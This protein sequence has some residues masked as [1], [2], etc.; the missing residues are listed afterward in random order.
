MRRFAR[1]LVVAS[2]AG[3][4]SSL[5]VAPAA[6]S[7]AGAASAGG[8]AAGATHDR[9]VSDL[10]ATNTPE[11][12]DGLPWAIHKIGD[13]VL[14]G[15]DFQ[16]VRDPGGGAIHERPFLFAF[17]AA[18]GEVDPDF[19]PSLA[20]EV[21]AL[22]PGPDSDT[23]YVGGR[24]NH[25]GGQQGWNK[26]V[27]MSLTDG[28]VLTS[29]RAPPMNGAVFDVDDAGGRLYVGGKFTHT[30]A[31]ATHGLVTL[32]PH[33]G[34]RDPFLDVHLTEHHNYDGQ[35]GAQAPVG[36]DRIDITP[37][38][39]TAVVI[40]NF[41]RAN[42][43]DRDQVLLLDLTGASAE[44]RDWHTNHFKPRCS[45][46]AFDKWVRDVSFSPDGSYFVVVTTG[47]PHRNTLCDTASRWETGATGSD[48]HPTW[49]N[50]T[51]GDTLLSVAVTDAAVYVGGHQR[52]QNNHL[53]LDHADTGAVGRPGLAA[54]DPASGVD[55]SWNPGRNPRGHGATVLHASEDGLYVGSDTD[56]VGNWE[57]FRPRL[58]HFPLA[59]GEV[60]PAGQSATLPG[61]VHFADV[62]VD[63]GA[64]VPQILYRVNAAGPALPALDSGPDWEADNAASSPYRTTGSLTSTL[65]TE[66]PQ[67]QEP[68]PETTPIEV[69]SSIRWDPPSEPAMQW[70]FP[71]PSGTPVEVR[72]YFADRCWCT[73]QPGDRVMDILLDGEPAAVAFDVVEYAGYNRGSMLAFPATSDGSI[74]IEFQHVVENPIVSGIEIVRDG[75]PDG[76]RAPGIGKR[77]FDGEA[78]GDLVEVG[79]A[80]GTD[81]SA[82][83]GAFLVDDQLFYGMA[84]G[85]FW[86][87]S[88]EDAVVGMP[89]QL[90]PHSDPY[91]DGVPTHSGNSTYDGVPT[92]FMDNL[93]TVRGM[94]YSGGMLFYTRAGQNTLFWRWFNPESGLAGSREFR[95]PATGGSGSLNH[96]GAA[97]GVL[98]VSGD[99][100]YWS[101]ADD[102]R[103]VRRPLVDHGPAQEQVTT[104]GTASRQFSWGGA[105]EAVS[106]PGIDGV[107]WRAPGA[108]LRQQ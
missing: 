105:A 35:Q 85:T 28:S 103:L 31:E 72:L 7:G 39:A 3:L 23:V 82:L 6:P 106:G 93:A 56:W 84:D 44:I 14:V 57:H 47:G 21:L 60:P 2:V 66:V 29:F 101:R 12:Q 63:S 52:W 65:A 19:A 69:F 100:V 16:S 49:V 26:L 13:R 25:A 76:P 59:G 1:L 91:W 87:R 78:A 75:D 86:R 38:G 15:G 37:D 53:G 41:K 79:G 92:T 88:F 68:V 107:D 20:N 74:E 80:D 54:L 9:V 36:A 30:G 61:E 90:T 11:I 45:W 58:A 94:Y 24:F 89:E 42:G 67:V 50:W 43:L 55:L 73:H 108:F 18:T 46:R 70:T 83:R 27:L 17:D 81:W 97:S 33:T 77:S 95:L 34:E 102:G 104:A 96:L 64:G 22:H 10:P 51:G 40:G 8:A 99:H 5:L 62:E 4:A 71:V 32:D 98:F 48:L